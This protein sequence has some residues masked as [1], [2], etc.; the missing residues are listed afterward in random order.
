MRPLGT[1]NAFQGQRRLLNRRGIALYTNN[2]TRAGH[3]VCVNVLLQNDLSGKK[4]TGNQQR[5]DAL[6]VR[7]EIA[8]SRQAG[9][10]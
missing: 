3:I 10:Q 8:L 6:S 4:H 2:T 1:I 7:R 9:I 5:N